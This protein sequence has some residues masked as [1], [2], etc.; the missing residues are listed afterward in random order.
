MEQQEAASQTESNPILSVALVE[1]NKVDAGIAEL[2]NRY[3][4]I[5][6]DVTTT[7]GM[8]EAKK[9]RL[10]VREP[11]YAVE[12]IRK[13]QASLIRAA[14]TALNSEAERITNAL[15]AIEDPIDAQIKAEEE[16]KQREKEEAER[17]ERMRVEAIRI[18][19]NSIVATP[20]VVSSESWSAEEIQTE[21]DALHGMQIDL[22]GY[23]EFT[24]EAQH[25]RQEAVS[26]LIA[27]RDREIARAESAAQLAEQQR[28]I[29]ELNA[30]LA[31]A[32]ALLKAKAE[33]VA[34]PAVEPA[35]AAEPVAEV[36]PTQVETAPVV[37]AAPAKDL[38]IEMIEQDE[39]R[40]FNDE[41]PGTE[42]VLFAVQSHFGV[43]ADVAKRY[44]VEA[45]NDL[46]F[47]GA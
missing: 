20:A 22:D 28:Q 35:P 8:E 2:A 33:P 9:A 26:K 44:I 39:S 46:A 5:A 11:R 24:A 27:L 30:K 18:A 38:P 10:A 6:F 47:L 21:I 43:T 42:R 14:Q 40:L 15:R 41:Y 31:A 19:I 37:A 23:Q 34:A 45:G 1:L 29:A 7:K 4:G 32:E 17:K 25:A 36:A 3:G 16:R 13:E 12:R